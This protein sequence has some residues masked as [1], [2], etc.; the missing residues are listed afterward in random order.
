MLDCED[1]GHDAGAISAD[2]QAI[3]INAEAAAIAECVAVAGQAV[4]PGAFVFGGTEK[5]T[6]P[7][8]FYAWCHEISSDRANEGP[9]RA[10]HEP[11]LARKIGQACAIPRR[12]P[13]LGRE[14][15][16]PERIAAQQHPGGGHG[17]GQHHQNCGPDPKDQIPQPRPFAGGFAAVAHLSFQ[18]PKIPIRAPTSET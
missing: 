7:G 3:G 12:R 14:A 2:Q 16:A 1:L 8:K 4:G 10:F 9:A 6:R 5:G 13:G 18:A 17:D 11:L 15:L